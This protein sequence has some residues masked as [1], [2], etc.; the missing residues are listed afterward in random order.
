MSNSTTP[1]ILS[2]QRESLCQELQQNRHYLAQQLSTND[3]AFPRSLTMRLLTQKNASIPMVEWPQTG[4]SIYQIITSSFYLIN[5]LKHSL[6]NHKDNQ[7][8]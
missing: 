7:Q 1:T 5:S 4:I 2:K 6:F 8:R 3:K